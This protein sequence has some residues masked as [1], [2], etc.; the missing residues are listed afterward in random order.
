MIIGLV[1]ADVPDSYFTYP[2]M[3]IDYLIKAG[4]VTP[5]MN[6]K[7]MFLVNPNWRHKLINLIYDSDTVQ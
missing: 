2:D 7:N 3:F 5:Y 1:L 6:Y 4:H